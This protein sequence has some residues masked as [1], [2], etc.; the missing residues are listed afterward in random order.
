MLLNLN[1]GLFI[2]VLWV[3]GQIIGITLVNFGYQ[4]N[5]AGK[6]GALM[7]VGGIIGSQIIGNMLQSN[8][9]FKLMLFIV[10]FISL[11]FGISVYVFIESLND[12]LLMILFFF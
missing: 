5:F 6:I 7:E 8:G 2:G 10:C 1:F 9:K 3:I 11:I 4:I 12:I